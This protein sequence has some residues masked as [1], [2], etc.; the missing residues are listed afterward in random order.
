[1][2]FFAYWWGQRCGPSSSKPQSCTGKQTYYTISYHTIP[3]QASTCLTSCGPRDVCVGALT[4]SANYICQCIPPL[5]P[6]PSTK[7]CTANCKTNTDCDND[8]TCDVSTGLCHCNTG[9][10]SVVGSGTTCM[11]QSYPCMY[12]CMYVCIYVC[13]SIE[14]NDIKALVEL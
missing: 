11:R 5:S 7:T 3:Y 14:L 1:M 13:T 2:L 6:S 12:V 10:F 9:Y 8:S 4:A